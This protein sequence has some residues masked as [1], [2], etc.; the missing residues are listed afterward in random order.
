MT[1]ALLYC[2]GGGIGDSLVA[3]VVARALRQKFEQVDA[4]TLPS[5]KSA[6]ERVPDVDDVLVD[7]GSHENV[8]AGELAAKTYDACVITWATARAASVAAKAKIPIRVGQSRRLYSSRFTHRVSVRSELGDVATPWAQIQLDY[9]RALGCDAASID[10]DFVPTASDA[11]EA[12]ALIARINVTDFMIL[13]PTNAVA[14]A[15]GIWPTR[16][17]AALARSLAETFGVSILLS[18]APNDAR[19]NAAIASETHDD[20]VHDTAGALGI[21]AFGALAQKARAFVGIT[22]GTMHV[23]AAVGAPTIGIFPFQSDVPDRWA[24]QGPRTATVRASFP[25]HTGDTKERCADYAC[26]ANLDVGRVVAA[27]KALLSNPR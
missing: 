1:R 11:E 7:D 13:H 17:W 2:A 22:T 15:R 10:P 26:I 9:A 21:G 27:T 14:S 19:I 18:G 12:R 8:L 3:T 23:A 4:L 25:C 5:H 20:R 6:L 16:G 24:P